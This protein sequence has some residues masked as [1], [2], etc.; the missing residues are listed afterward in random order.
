MSIENFTGKYKTTSQ[1]QVEAVAQEQLERKQTQQKKLEQLKERAKE[2][3]LV[4]RNGL[5]AH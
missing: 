4:K 3:S 2:M 1:R 5:T